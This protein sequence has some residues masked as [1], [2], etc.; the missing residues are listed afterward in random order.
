M[1]VGSYDTES[2][3]D[4][5]RIYD[6][7][8]TSSYLL[9]SLSGTGYGV[10]VTSSGRYMHLYFYSDGSVTDYGFESTYTIIGG[11]KNENGMYD[12]PS[13][14]YVLVY[15]FDNITLDTLDTITMSIVIKYM[16]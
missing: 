1:N 16:F 7:A 14:I 15:F 4:R 11:R 8:S 2:C 3:C 10:T 9:R 5:L 6:G 12:T 13:T